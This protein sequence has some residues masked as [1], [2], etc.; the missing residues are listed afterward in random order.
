[1]LPLA[2]PT[3]DKV[4]KYLAPMEDIYSNNHRDPVS[5]KTVNSLGWWYMPLIPA[6]LGDI[7]TSL[8]YIASSRLLGL[9][10]DP[11]SKRPKVNK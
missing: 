10:G 4:L 6:E 1:M 7:G 9:L 5:K 2:P 3:R 8:I 11:V